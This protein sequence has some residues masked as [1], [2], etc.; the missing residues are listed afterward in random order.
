M[1]LFTREKKN[2]LTVLISFDLFY[3]SLP[4][5]DKL[6]TLYRSCFTN[7]Q[8]YISFMLAWLVSHNCYSST[9][10]QEPFH[11]VPLHNL[12][13]HMNLGRGEIS[14]GIC[15]TQVC[16]EAPSSQGTEFWG[17]PRLSS[18]TSHDQ[19]LYIWESFWATRHTDMIPHIRFSK[20]FSMTVAVTVPYARASVVLSRW[21]NMW[22][23]FDFTSQ[24]FMKNKRSDGNKIQ[25]F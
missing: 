24:D 9:K 3:S 18:V 22:Q 4:N 12:F 25:V 21:E 8:Y 13:Y 14:Y 7:F 11:S 2:S 16:I 19:G 10:V 20:T 1:T 15:R 17:C 23:T 6:V 5:M